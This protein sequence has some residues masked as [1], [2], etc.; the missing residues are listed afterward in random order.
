MVDVRR[1]IFAHLRAQDADAAID[2]MTDHRESLNKYIKS[3]E[4]LRGTKLRKARP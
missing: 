3:Q 4:K 1:C 2:E